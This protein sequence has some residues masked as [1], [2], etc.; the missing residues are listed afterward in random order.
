MGEGDFGEVELG[1]LSNELSPVECGKLLE[2]MNAKS[3]LSDD[4]YLQS[5]AR[6]SLNNESTL[7][8]QLELPFSNRDNCY[9]KLQDWS[10][11]LP[12]KNFDAG[13]KLTQTKMKEFF[14]WYHFRLFVGII[15]EKSHQWARATMETELQ[16]LGRPDLAKYVKK[17]RRFVRYFDDFSKNSKNPAMQTNSAGQKAKKKVHVVKPVDVMKKSHKATALQYYPFGS[18][19]PAKAHANL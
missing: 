14:S 19:N 5:N 8:R 11:N 17:S 4:A 1:Y 15:T 16:N 3:P 7:R 2:T 6:V 9:D 12:G 18:M 13:K 10:R